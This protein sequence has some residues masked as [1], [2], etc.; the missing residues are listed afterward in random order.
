MKNKHPLA[1]AQQTRIDLLYGGTED[2][3]LRESVRIA[4]DATYTLELEE[5]VFIINSLSNRHKFESLCMSLPKKYESMIRGATYFGTKLID[6]LKFIEHL[7]R[8]CKI[9]MIIIN[10]FDLAVYNSRHRMQLLEFIKRLRDEMN[11]RVV[12]CLN[13]HPHCFGAQGSLKLMANTI[14]EIGEKATSEE[15]PMLGVKS[16]DVD[17]S[18][19]DF[20]KEPFIPQQNDEVLDIAESATD[21]SAVSAE[22]D[23]FV[24]PSRKDSEE[25]EADQ[26]EPTVINECTNGERELAEYRVRECDIPSEYTPFSEAAARKYGMA[27]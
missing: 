15:Q 19:K 18:R 22:G 20:W 21:E 3:I 25:V 13:N 14:T 10:S 9:R 11:L 5:S 1:D 27:A 17:M 26:A 7:I 16:E 8:I 4:R 23:C 6:K 24:V 12:I 2:E